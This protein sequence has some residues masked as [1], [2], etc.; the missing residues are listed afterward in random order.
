VIFAVGIA[1]LLVA[2][3][4]VILVASGGSDET[5]LASP[6]P[7]ECLNNWNDDDAALV[8]GRHNRTF[9][10]Y[11]SAQVG[12]LQ[13]A[14]PEPRISNDSTGTCA[15]VFGRADL[16]PEAEAAGF[17]EVS[18]AWVPLSE[19]YATNVLSVLQA[20]AIAGANVTLSSDGELAPG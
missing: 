13:S 19:G 14:G 2:S 7:S 10:Q 1:T 3:L 16:D 11:E 17:S 12:Y 8:Q 18:G 20:E 4:I 9:H 6:A 15:V 5:A